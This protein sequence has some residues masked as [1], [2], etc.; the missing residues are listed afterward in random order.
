MVVKKEAGYTLT[1]IGIDT[2][3]V[4]N[5]LREGIIVEALGAPKQRPLSLSLET[6]YIL[7]CYS[8]SGMTVNRLQRPRLSPP[9]VLTETVGMKEGKE[10]TCQTCI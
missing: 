5:D 1:F 4:E 2:N 6:E 7:S 8:A 10:K 9:Q 3:I